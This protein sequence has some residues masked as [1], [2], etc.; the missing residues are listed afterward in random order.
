MPNVAVVNQSIDRDLSLQ[1]NLAEDVPVKRIL[2][3]SNS[4][5]RSLSAIQAV[6]ADKSIPS[7]QFQ[8]PDRQATL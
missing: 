2:P 5:H 3:F 8:M 1:G 4:P 7:G 6:R